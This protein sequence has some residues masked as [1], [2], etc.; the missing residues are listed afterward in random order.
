[1][2]EFRVEV[3]SIRLHQVS[4]PALRFLDRALG[5]ADGYLGQWITWAPSDTRDA[6]IYTGNLSNDLHVGALESLAR[7]ELEKFLDFTEPEWRLVT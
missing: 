3:G 4:R 5:D 6:F 2:S 1:M 7:G